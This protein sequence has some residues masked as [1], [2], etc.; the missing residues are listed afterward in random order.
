M[1]SQW[2]FGGRLGLR[3][4][5]AMLGVIVMTACTDGVA[6]GAASRPAVPHA[7]P[8][9][10]AADGPVYL[11]GPRHDSYGAGQK[12][13]T[14]ANAARITSRWQDAPGQEFLASPTVADGAVYIGSNSGWFYKLSASTGAV[15][16]KV[17]LG[18][19]PAGTCY[20]PRGIA[21]TATV[22]A[23]P[24]NSATVYVGAADGYLYALNAS[25][26]RLRW[27]SVIAKPSATISNYY[28]WSSPTVANGKI[29]IGLSSTCENPPVR[30]AVIA[31]NQATGKKTAKFYVVPRGQ[32]GGGVWSSI[33]A[34][35]NGDVYAT[36]GGGP[37]SDPR[38]GRSESILKFAPATL[39]LLGSWQ[40]PGTDYGTDFGGSPVIFGGYVGACNKDG[41]FYALNQS[42]MRLAWQQR[43]GAHYVPTVGAEC[44]GSPAYNGE[45]L[46]FGGPAVTIGGRAHRGSVQERSPSTG[47]LIWEI[48][49]PEGVTGSPT[50]DGAGVLAVGTYDSGSAADR[51]YLIG[52]ASGRI[53]RR[54]GVGKDFAQSVFADGWLFTANVNGVYGWAPRR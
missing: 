17:F 43:I 29:Y 8:A 53:L 11:D 7:R 1:S 2:A 32:V 16:H 42:T 28:D 14:A 51:T 4:I 23:G 31:Y 18:T 44:D 24:G 49:L 30:G 10:T 22:A 20:N 25:N 46:F 3:A 36:T 54:L 50:L 33:A 38:L 37:L 41:I 27:R 21:D 52:A 40:V 5:A 34:G 48:G 15:Q 45:D 39:R 47:K 6:A 19:Q 12:A 13:I 26:L 9:V 35:P